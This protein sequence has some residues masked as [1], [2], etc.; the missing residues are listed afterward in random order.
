MLIG[1]Q[2]GRMVKSGEAE[3][4]RDGRGLQE[5]CN[6]DRLEKARGQESF[7]VA[8]SSS[9]RLFRESVSQNREIIK[10]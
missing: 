3:C 9:S 6:D 10:N 7:R 1:R 8:S 4:R 5:L 2:E